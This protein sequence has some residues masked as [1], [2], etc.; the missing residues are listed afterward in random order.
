MRVGVSVFFQM[1]PQL[2]DFV[3]PEKYSWDMRIALQALLSF[4]VC[5]NSAGANPCF[6]CFVLHCTPCLY[7]RNK[8]R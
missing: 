5:S 6:D 8:R 4:E 1:L 3:T 7:A 2:R